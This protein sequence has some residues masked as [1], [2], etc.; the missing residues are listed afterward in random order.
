MSDEMRESTSLELFKTKYL[1]EWFNWNILI[2]YC[3]TLF[4]LIL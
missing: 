4:I 1:N 3:I 2:I